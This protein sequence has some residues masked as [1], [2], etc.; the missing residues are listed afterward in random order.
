[1]Q[2]DASFAP[3][4]EE[5]YWRA[6]LAQNRPLVRTACV[7]FVILNAGRLLDVALRHPIPITRLLAPGL[8]LA[9]S[10]ALT[11]LVLRPALE[12]HYLR[13]AGWIVPLRNLIVTWQLT[14]AAAHGEPEVLMSLPILM[15]GPFLFLCLRFPA[16]L[17]SGIVT[18][19]TFL[20]GALFFGLAPAILCRAA[21]LLAAT[22]IACIFGGARAESAWRGSFLEQRRTRNQAQLDELTGLANRR[23]FDETLQVCWER[24]S[25]E[26][27][28]L[29]V[30][31]IDVDHFKAFNDRNGHLAGDEALQRIAAAL[32]RVATA[33]G[34]VVARFGGE[35]FAA[36]TY[37][38]DAE[39]AYQLAERMRQS[40]LALRIRQNA[41]PAAEGITISLGVAVVQPLASRSCRGAVQLA[42]QALYEAK[43]RGRNAVELVDDAAYRLLVTGV[44]PDPLA[45]ARHG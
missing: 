33:S 23:V 22:L 30:L 7:L 3:A 31:L 13:W 38:L 16:A 39:R 27:R 21:L 34:A 14:A 9:G 26:R 10:I 15:I 45:A 37:D 6:H 20:A 5:A 18:L 2:E 24:G 41:G 28:C 32:A 1:M 17:T 12:H 36:V 11:A 44:F 25:A 4:L 35:E 42:D 40:V 8:V 43:R 29:A 19:S